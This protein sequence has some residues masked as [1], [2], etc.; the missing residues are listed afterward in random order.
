MGFIQISYYFH[1]DEESR[2]LF[3]TLANDAPIGIFYSGPDGIARYVNK[4]LAEIAG[5]S[6]EELTGKLWREKIHPDER[7]AVTELWLAKVHNAEPWHV[8]FRFQRPDGNDIWVLGHTNPQLDADGKVIGHVGTIMDISE[9]KHR[10]EELKL[11][12]KDR[13]RELNLQKSALDEHAIVSSADIKGNIIY[14]NDKFCNISGFS[15]DELM[16]QNHKILKSGEHSLEFY[17]DLWETISSG[18][19]WNGNIKNRKKD[20]DYY[21]VDATIVP[22][23]DDQKKPFQYVSIRTDITERMAA[24]EKAEVANQ[25]KTD[26]LSSMSHELR[27][28]LNAILGFAQIL[29]LDPRDPLTESQQ[30]KV[31]NIMNAGEHL[32]TLINEVLDLAKIESGNMNFSIED[33]KITKVV[34]ECLTLVNE[35]AAN[36]GIK[37]TIPDVDKD[38][39]LVRADLTRLKQVVLNLLSNG[40]KYNCD[41]GN[42][43]ISYDKVAP[44][45]IRVSFK[46]TGKGISKQRQSELFKAFSRLGKE[47]SEIEGTGI[48]L[49]VCKDLIALM[50]GRIGFESEEDKGSTF[51]IELPLATN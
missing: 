42:L 6:A 41:N 45:M 28:P 17:E 1:I 25:A 36:R 35:M 44:G 32:L 7:D 47:S 27:T 48:G 9:R 24:I 49:V 50:G 13:T 2:G 33:T 38:M 8:E 26:F 46:D 5:Y 3:Y 19:V 4:A 40:I 10:E 39:E 11:R 51:W 18:K 22:F 37:I 16:G 34:N 43:I 30:R 31:D 23:L 20:G 12:I 14:V 15:R 29:Q 21:W